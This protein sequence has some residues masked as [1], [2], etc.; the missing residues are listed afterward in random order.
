MHRYSHYIYTSLTRISDL[1]KGRFR[2]AALP[3]GQ[4]RMADY[5]I[6]EVLDAA[7]GRF[8]VELENGRM[9]E[10]METQRLIGALG[11][12][13]ATLEATG[14]WEAVGE[15]GHM[16]LLTGAGLFGRLTSKSVFVPQVVHLKYRG[17]V[18]V[19]DRPVG[20]PDYVTPF[21]DVPFELPVIVLFGT[22][23]SAG[24]TTAARLIA[25][26]L[27]RMGLKVV[28]AKLTGAGRYKDILSVYD[29]GV[30]HVFDFVDVGLPSSICPPQVYRQALRQLLNRL[31]A[32]M[33]DVAVV[34]IGASP[35]EP[36]NGDIALREIAPH[37]RLSVLCASDP[38]AV[39]GVM[40]SFELKPDLVSG[41][42]TNTLGG[43]ELVKKL[44]KVRAFNLID[45]ENLPALRALIREKLKEVFWGRPGGKGE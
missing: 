31:S 13:H 4:W 33:A 44:C 34:E 39:L 7:G 14:S 37:I 22:S 11:V 30:D 16:H 36:Y 3:R 10:V 32:T 42:A 27:K 45:P 8:K 25:R 38:Y 20:M 6:C 41:V 23:M 18:L 40:K 5:V 28:A 12:R 1:D 15:D 26:Q 43:I 17:H 24:K 19:D 2:V 29:A 21:P 35:L 9:M